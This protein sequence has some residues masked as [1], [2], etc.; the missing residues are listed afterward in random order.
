MIT[1]GNYANYLTKVNLFGYAR[2]D[3]FMLLFNLQES[4]QSVKC[5]EVINTLRVNQNW[6]YTD[7]IIWCLPRKPPCHTFPWR[8]HILSFPLKAGR[9]ISAETCGLDDVFPPD[10]IG[11]GPCT[12]FI[13][14]IPHII[15]AFLL[16]RI[17]SFSET[18]IP[19]VGMAMLVY[20]MVC[21]CL[22][23]GVL[24]VIW[25]SILYVMVLI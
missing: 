1:G 13:M 16:N 6:H 15:A 8:W 17:N 9:G 3:I 25:S 2:G 7:T 12:Q 5:A 22:V 20:W 14:Y 11:S 19:K 23:S 18:Y 24:S 4:L 10:D 21:Y